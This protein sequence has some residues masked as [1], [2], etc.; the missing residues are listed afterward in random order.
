[1]MSK[2]LSIFRIS[3]IVL[4]FYLP[5]IHLYAPVQGT[6]G[7]KYVN[8][9]WDSMLHISIWPIMLLTFAVGLQIASK[10]QEAKNGYNKKNSSTIA[11][12]HPSLPLHTYESLVVQAAT[13][14]AF[15]CIA[16]RIK[17]RWKL[18]AVETAVIIIVACITIAQ[19][20]QSQLQVIQPGWLWNPFLWGT[21][22]VYSTNAIPKALEGVCIDEADTEM[23][24]EP[25]CLS[26]VEWEELR[27]VF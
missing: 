22:K 20:I 27:C 21:Y 1:M 11:T 25:L 6:T 9:F 2:L 10:H 24:V 23:N 14:R 19:A 17:R 5:L 12:N 16:G 26:K 4:F 13:L 8:V 18:P 15:M 3:S 7:L